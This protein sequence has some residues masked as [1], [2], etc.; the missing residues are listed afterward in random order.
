MFLNSIPIVFFLE[1]TQDW[2]LKGAESTCKKP[3]A[4]THIIFGQ[5]KSI[6]LPHSLKNYFWTFENNIPLRNKTEGLG[7]TIKFFVSREF[8]FAF[9]LNDAELKKVSDAVNKKEKI[10]KDIKQVLCIGSRL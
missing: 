4:K 2:Q 6:F 3:T 7:V 10:K 5:D 8:G 9:G 1:I